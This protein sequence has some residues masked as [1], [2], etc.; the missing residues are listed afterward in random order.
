M[1]G[2]SFLAFLGKQARTAFSLSVLRAINLLVLRASPPHNL[3]VVHA[4]CIFIFTSLR[5]APASALL[6]RFL[7]RVQRH[8]H[9]EKDLM[10]S[11]SNPFG[12]VRAGFDNRW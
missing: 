7:S 8:S 2:L 4:G 6:I 10:G 5:F 12:A 9:S 11:F 3:R 1:K